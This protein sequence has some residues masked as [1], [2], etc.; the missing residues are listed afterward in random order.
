MEPQI[1]HQMEQIGRD[2]KMLNYFSM[3]RLWGTPAPHLSPAENETRTP[4]PR[5]WRGLV[6]EFLGTLFLV[7]LCVASGVV[8]SQFP[9]QKTTGLSSTVMVVGIIQGFGAAALIAALSHISGGN[10]NP[11]VTL[12][13]L[14]VG[15]MPFMRA[16]FYMAFQILGGM[17]GAGLFA[18]CIPRSLWNGLGTTTLNSS[19][20]NRGQGFLMEF[21]VTSLLIFVVL[22][23]AADRVNKTVNLAPVPIGFAL[24]VGVMAAFHWTGGSLNPARTFGPAV[25]SGEWS[26]QWV[27]WLGQL[28]AAVVIG[29]LYRFIFLTAPPPEED[30]ASVRLLTRSHMPAEAAQMTPTRDGAAPAA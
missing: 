10:L 22:A 5:I 6:G 19:L 8:A 7:F 28:G 16:V 21:M 27:Y 15:K 14:V 1:E 30:V 23:T 12:A 26:N 13:L 17:V 9:E 2:R 11:A 25:I 29:L 20:N 3:W 24:A 4:W 18:A